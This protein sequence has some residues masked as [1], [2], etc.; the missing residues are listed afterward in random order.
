MDYFPLFADLRDQPCLVVGGGNVAARKAH[1][2]AAAGARLTVVA[3]DCAPTMQ[4][5]VA[6]GTVTWQPGT[7]APELVTDHLLVIA[8]TDD[9]T[10]NHTIAGVARA[11]RRLCNVVDDA[12]ASSFIVPGIVDRSPLVVAV[13]SGGQAPVL[14]RWLRQ[15][16]ERWLP[17][18]CGDLAR[19]AGTWRSRVRERLATPRQRRAFWDTLLTG[20][21]GRH[22]LAGEHAAAEAAAAHLL[23]QTGARAGGKAWLVGAGPGDP[24]L[25]SLR[26]LQA[27]EQAD[28]VLHDRLVSPQLL[29]S[30]RREAEIIAVGKT[31]GGPATSQDEI[32]RLL[33]AHVRAGR[34]VCR[35]KGGDPFIFGRGGEEALA[36]AAAGLPFEVVPGITAASGC[37]AAAGIPLTHRGLAT[38]VT[39]V[40]AQAAEGAPPD[41]SALA[42]AN[43]TLAIYMGSRRV[44]DI[45]AGLV[46]HGRAPDTTAAVIGAGT[47]AQ[48]QVVTGTL[49]DIAERWTASAPPALA[50]ALMLVGET[51]ALAARLAR[52][53]CAPPR[54]AA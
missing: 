35:L 41:W 16:L 4:A 50:P 31:G 33:I 17:A 37:A 10:L 49:A 47:T 6:A 23:E 40:T 28:V 51:V 39:F 29:R 3:P 20:E 25:I 26:G 18:G 30:A 32:E 22:F 2:L 21:P 11:A 24:A 15:R 53:N 19:W 27:L 14:T 34:R 12:A 5:L 8:A 9:S 38:A 42:H 7:F 54:A 46:A 43:H 52:P 36:L 45:A 44:A 13:S 1:E 48:Q